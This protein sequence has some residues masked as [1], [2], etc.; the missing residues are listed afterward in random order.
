MIISKEDIELI[1][2]ME[3]IGK[4]GYFVDSVQLTNLYNKVLEKRVNPTNCSAC[5][6]SRLR[7]LVDALN[8]FERLSQKVEEATKSEEPVTVP[9][10]ENKPVKTKKKK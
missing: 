6:K 8:R 1:R 9:Q 7:E 5:L 10:E 2:K 4:R 3:E